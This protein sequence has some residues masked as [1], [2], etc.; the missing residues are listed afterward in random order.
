MLVCIKR[1]HL[2]ESYRHQQSLHGA[3]NG[4]SGSNA[5]FAAPNLMAAEEIR[6]DC[7]QLTNNGRFVVTGSIY[8]PPQVWDMKVCGSCYQRL[9][10]L[11]FIQYLYLIILIKNKVIKNRSPNKHANN[12]L[13]YGIDRIRLSCFFKIYSFM[14]TFIIFQ[15]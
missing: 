8:G 14:F 4:L 5:G 3:S 2:Q 7:A 10:T 15:K 11:L 13:N 6:V 1:R 12:F 9:G